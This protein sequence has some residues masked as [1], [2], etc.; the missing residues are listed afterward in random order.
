MRVVQ[1][2][3][4]RSGTP[5]GRRRPM[6]WVL[7][8]LALCCASMPVGAGDGE[9]APAP[10]ACADIQSIGAYE[11]AVLA[12]VNRVRTAPRAYAESLRALYA[13]IDAHGIYRRGERRM[14][15]GEGPAV[16]DE[17]LRFLERVDPVPA[18][19]M[20][21]CL[22]LAATRHARAKGSVGGSGHFGANGWTPSRRASAVTREPVGC[23]EN[24][25][26]GYDDVAEM[27][28]ALVVDDGVPGRGHR[29]NLFD[30][31]MRSL[32]AGRAPHAVRRVMDV[33]LLCLQDVQD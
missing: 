30:P 21:S 13:G 29:M 2:S 17:A 18:L 28:A 22:N 31:R 19:R 33:Q 5:R 20:A 3:T 4:R 25:A 14:A 7:G 15:V 24:I 16:V 12:E 9:P 10:V 6:A 26:Y 11:A 27:V 23:S 8:W 1:G 32:G